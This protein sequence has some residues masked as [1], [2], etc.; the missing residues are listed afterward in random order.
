MK[1]TDGF[2]NELFKDDM[3]M[4]QRQDHSWIVGLISEIREP[5]VLAAANQPMAMPGV[6]QIIPMPVNMMFDAK[7]PVVPNVIKVVKPLQ[8]NKS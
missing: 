5:S 2:G 1:L 3:V 4:I 8:F 6:I 7:N